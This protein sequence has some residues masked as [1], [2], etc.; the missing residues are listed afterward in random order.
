LAVHAV[1]NAIT[2]NTAAIEIHTLR[3][4]FLLG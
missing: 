3:I 2:V 4:S 1:N